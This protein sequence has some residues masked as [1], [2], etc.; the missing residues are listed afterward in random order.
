MAQTSIHIEPVKAGSE[1]HNTR[2]R[3]LDYVR[4]DLTQ[5]N[6]SYTFTDYKGVTI[7]ELQQEIKGDYAAEH[8]KKLH[9]R[10]TPVREAVAVIEAGTTMQQLQNFC[11][12]CKSRWGISA[13]QIHMH[14]DEGHD[15]EDG[16]WHPNL[17]AHIVFDWY[18][19][20]THT[21]VKMSKQD[22]CEMQTL[23]AEC[24]EMERGVSSDRKHLNVIQQKN[25]AEAEKLQ[26]L[27]EQVKQQHEVHR[28]EL[29]QECRDLRKSGRSTVKAFDYL[30]KFEAVTPSAQEQQFRDNLDQECRR[31][32]PSE[33]AELVEHAHN[34]RIYLMN[35]I[36]AVTK[37]GRKLQDIAKDIPF[38]KR[39]RLKHEAEL[40]ARTANAE[41]EAREIT[42]KAENART[43]ARNA[44]EMANR[45]Q[46]SAEKRERQAQ[47]KLA[48]LEQ[49][50]AS[51]K[52]QGQAEGHAQGYTEAK[53]R[54]KTTAD[55]LQGQVETLNAEVKAL[56]GQVNEL[57]ETK[58]SWLQDFKD[59]AR[60]LTSLAPD[61]VLLLEQKGL[62]TA[63]GDTLWDDAKK[64]AEREQKPTVMGNSLRESLRLK[65]HK[66][67]GF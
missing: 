43:V 61:T 5:E 25:K 55:A 65:V 4:H 53:D 28:D 39:N 18:D 56:Q 20:R 50:I 42:L 7:D 23:L 10:A 16:E 35:T 11:Q 49:D 21:T 19:R 14:K 30:A 6:E 47:A 41:K 58:T 64:A 29:L 57:S 51:A 8:G 44:Q 1:M 37:I 60:A 32:L 2:T 38:F 46:L 40:Q 45:A 52:A 9:S 66:G 27:Q 48:T 63:V 62:R 54:Y 17:H 31:D 15:A 67:N 13:V 12:E 22:M 3:S 36:N 34:L 33:T 59:I 26:R 24:L